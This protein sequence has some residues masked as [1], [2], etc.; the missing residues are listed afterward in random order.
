[1]VIGGVPNIVV[2][3]RSWWLPN[4]YLTGCAAVSHYEEAEAQ[5]RWTSNNAITVTHSGDQL[6]WDVGSAPFHDSPC[7]TVTVRLANKR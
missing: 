3:V 5:I 6:Y 7:E 2:M 1:M 4:W